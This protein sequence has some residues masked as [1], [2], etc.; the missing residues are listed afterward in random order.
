M[1]EPGQKIICIDN[2]PRDGR[3]LALD[4]LSRIKV[5]EVYTILAIFESSIPGQY[6][7]SLE[8]VSTPFSEKL[9]HEIGYKSDRFRPYE[10]FLFADE[11]LNRIAEEI[12]EEFLVRIP[13]S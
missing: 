9:G 10:S 5:G 13:K 3:A 2:S 7:I 11:T 12:E 1:F 6:S 8:E 4:I